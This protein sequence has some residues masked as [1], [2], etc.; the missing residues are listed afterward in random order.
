M[1]GGGLDG[2]N[3]DDDGNYGNHIAQGGKLG[4]GEGME[5]AQ[6]QEG[7]E[8]KEEDEEEE[9]EEERFFEE[10]EVVAVAERKWAGMNKEGAL[11]PHPCPIPAPSPFE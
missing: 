9:E 3:E 10:G 2:N 4:Q 1:D 11:L 8:K 6:E 7:E 5:Q